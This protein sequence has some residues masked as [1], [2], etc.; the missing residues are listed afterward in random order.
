MLINTW[1]LF[2]A[3]SIAPAISPGPAILLAISNSLRYG[4]RA[5]FY[6]AL[7]NALGL[8]ILGFAVAFGLAALLEVSALAFTVVKMI[9]ALYLVYLGIKLW[10]DGK[11]IALP[12]QAVPLMGRRKL[13]AQA[14]LVSVTNPKALILLAALIPPFIDRAQPLLPQAAAMAVTYAGLCFLNHLMLAFASD[15]LRRFLS[16]PQR[17]LAVRR[18]LGTMF[19]GFGAA[20]AAANR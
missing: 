13:F 14:L 6:S 3:I 8:T 18:V 4:A 12:S 20:L 2:V 7:G 16:S 9:G 19:I 17:M 11:G 10:R 15:K 5:T 1:L